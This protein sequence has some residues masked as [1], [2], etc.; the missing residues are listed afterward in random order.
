MSE[1]A[2]RSPN[3]HSRFPFPDKVGKPSCLAFAPRWL[4][5]VVACPTSTPPGVEEKALRVP[6]PALGS[7]QER[8][9]DARTGFCIPGG[10]P[11]VLSKPSQGVVKEYATMNHHV[12]WSEIEACLDLRH[13][14]WRERVEEFGQVQAVED[15]SRG[16]VW[17]DDQVFEAILLAVLSSNTVWSKVEHVQ[18]DLS[19]LFDNF[20]LEAYASHSDTEI[21]N[22]FVSWFKGRKAGSVS[23]R[24]GLVNLAYAARI[25]LRHSKCHG[26][27]DDYFTSLMDQCADDPKQA[28]MRLGGQGRIQAAVARRCSRCGGVEE[29]RLRCGKAGPDT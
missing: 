13:T 28:A 16:R 4:R 8:T 5:G 11:Y 29:S 25:L 6:F 20:S 9:E 17:S 27:A 23:L 22:R 12:L 2:S 14:H 15:R 1:R 7:T 26:A 19:E 18:A 10:A 21:D 24:G 3:G